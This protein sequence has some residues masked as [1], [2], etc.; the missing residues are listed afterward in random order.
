M[1]RK[2]VCLLIGLAALLML[3]YQLPTGSAQTV[4][5][6]ESQLITYL[7]D[8]PRIKEAGAVVLDLT[9]QGEALVIDLSEEVLPSGTYDQALFTQLQADLDQTFNINQFYMTTFMVAGE[10]LE[11]WGRPLPEIDPLIGS[12][13][14]IPEALGV[15]P[16][17]GVKIALSP[18][19]GIYWNE[20]YSAWMY[21]RLEFWG[22]REDTLNL[23]IMQYVQTAL[24]NQGATVIPLREF[25]KSQPL[26]V[27]GYPAWHES[28][29][30]YAI[31]LGL[32]ASIW[33]GSNTNYNSDIRT[34]P[35]MA[36]YYGANLFISLHNNGWDGSLRGT[37]TYWDV[38]NHPG[39]QAFANAVHGRIINAI[40]QEYDPAWI[41]RGVK[42]TN[43]SYGEIYFA[44]MPAI[45]IEL[46][47]MDNIVDNAYLHDEAFKIL[48]ANAIAKGVCD[49]V[50]VTCNDDWTP[51][52]ELDKHFYLPLILK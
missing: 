41:N 49:F 19:H 28:A 37:E 15:G 27:S 38:N 1:I 40:R 47:F 36:N 2:S 35:Y 5:P 29:R 24:K 46:A 8:H 3:L 13:T 21:Q 22:I 7:K 52:P 34:R 23:E 50:G 32:P 42:S 45:L 4:R 25:D 44:Q 33:D 39:S 48:A 20:T 31:S 30:R 12:H 16:L 14:G 17:A 18:G 26:G 51:F 43:W 6:N 9:I 10:P 11:Y